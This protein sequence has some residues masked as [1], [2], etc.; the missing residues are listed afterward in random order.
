MNRSGAHDRAGI[1]KWTSV[2]EA[3]D[4]TVESKSAI[5]KGCGGRNRNNQNVVA[6]ALRS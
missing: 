4:T 1:D 3:S 5:R 6:L 2:T